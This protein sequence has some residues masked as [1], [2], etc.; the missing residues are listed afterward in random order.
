MDN[1]IIKL[2]VAFSSVIQSNKRVANRTIKGIAKK[3]KTSLN[4]AL[5]AINLFITKNNTIETKMTPST[6]LSLFT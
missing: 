6:N 1:N 5:F 2:I 4:V 3:N